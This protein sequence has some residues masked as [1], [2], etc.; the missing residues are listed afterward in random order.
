MTS[1]LCFMPQGG[2]YLDMLTPDMFYNVPYDVVIATTYS[3]SIRV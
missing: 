3:C 1:Y 2:P